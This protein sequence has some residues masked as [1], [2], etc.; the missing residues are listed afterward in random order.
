[1]N[2]STLTPR[3]TFRDVLAQVA[4][5][6]KT[7]LP[8]AV[9]GRLES[10]ARLVLQ[11]DVLFC[12]DG[13]VEVGS[14]DP[15]RYYKLV[16]PTCTC[17]DFTSGKAPESWCKHKIAA[18]L[19]RSVERVLARRAAAPPVPGVPDGLEPWPDNDPEPEP[20]EETHPMP[21]PL[22]EAPASCNVY[23]MIGG[24]KVQVTL[25]DTDEHRMLERLQVLLA[26]YPAAQPQAPAQP[27]RQEPGQSSSPGWCHKHGVQMTQTTK[28]GRSWWSHRTADGWCKGR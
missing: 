7:L 3:Q 24:H 15:T 25:R 20:T 5:Q 16:G 22:P 27:R 8:Q 10:A 11:G 1:M 12:D 18:N 26:Q 23:V 19:Q 4:E 9:N 13:S 21:T 6:A 14:S 2:T 28:E 17:T